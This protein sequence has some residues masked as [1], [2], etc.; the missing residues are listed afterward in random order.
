MQ[1]DGLLNFIEG[2]WADSYF[3]KILAVRKPALDQIITDVS[4]FNTSDTEKAVSAAW[5]AFQAAQKK[6]RSSSA[7]KNICA[8][9]E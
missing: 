2:E 1:N 6:R 7:E 8:K 4:M 9:Q 3:N 5:E